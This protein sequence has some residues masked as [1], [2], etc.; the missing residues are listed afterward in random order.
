MRATPGHTD[1]SSRR[2]LAGRFFCLGFG[3]GVTC[4][5]S[6]VVLAPLGCVSVCIRV[7]ARRYALLERRVGEY[8]SKNLPSCCLFN[9]A[10]LGSRMGSTEI[11]GDDVRGW[12]HDFVGSGW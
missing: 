2:R 1:A 3:R 6:G 8:P 9:F 10:T 11:R 7:P 4:F 5:P 12:D